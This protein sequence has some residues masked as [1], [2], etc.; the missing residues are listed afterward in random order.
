MHQYMSKNKTIF[1]L[2]IVKL[3]GNILKGCIIINN[4]KWDIHK[5][6]DLNNIVF[7]DLLLPSNYNDDETWNKFIRI[8]FQKLWSIVD[9]LV[10]LDKKKNNNNNKK[11]NN[12]FKI[13]FKILSVGEIILN[14][15][16][17]NN[18]NIEIMEILFRIKLVNLDPLL[19]NFFNLANNCD[20]EN[21]IAYD[22]NFNK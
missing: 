7:E 4:D 14:N 1:S 13:T 9:L 19:D 17:F 22:P 21:I 12:I 2:E 5:E 18:M 10:K 20:I 8:E 6:P 11:F 3:L 16:T 15:N